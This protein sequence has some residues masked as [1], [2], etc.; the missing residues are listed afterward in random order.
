MPGLLDSP[1]AA[2]LDLHGLDAARARQAVERLLRGKGGA[3]SGQVVHIVTGRGRG[4]AGQP[5]LKPLVRRLL[6]GDFS[7]FV[8]EFS[9][10]LNEGGYIARLR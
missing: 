10:D 7:Q 5:V 1:I 8:R 4:S 6:A 3:R 9:Q 2:T